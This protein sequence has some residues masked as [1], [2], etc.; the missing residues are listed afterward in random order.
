MDKRQEIDGP[1]AEQLDFVPC[2][3]IFQNT[4]SERRAELC[5]DKRFKKSHIPHS[6]GQGD[7]PNYTCAE[8]LLRG[9]RRVMLRDALPIGLF[10]RIHLG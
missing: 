9:Q 1:Q 2:G 6:Q 3:Q 10:S 7:L 4:K 5:Q 8:R